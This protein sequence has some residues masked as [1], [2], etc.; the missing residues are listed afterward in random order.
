[1]ALVVDCATTASCVTMRAVPMRKE[2]A[3]PRRRQLPSKYLSTHRLK[4]GHIEVE[5]V[6]LIAQ[7]IEFLGVLSP[8]RSDGL[9]RMIAAADPYGRIGSRKDAVHPLVA[10]GGTIMRSCT[11][12]FVCMR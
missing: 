11:L 5:R 7:P 10:N 4:L 12:S 2:L 1:M 6:R 3:L 8:P 9:H